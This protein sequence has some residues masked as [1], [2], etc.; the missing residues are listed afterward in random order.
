MLEVGA[1]VTGDNFGNQ[2]DFGHGSILEIRKFDVG[3]FGDF[4]VIHIEERGG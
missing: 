3:Q 1:L 2:T 4:I